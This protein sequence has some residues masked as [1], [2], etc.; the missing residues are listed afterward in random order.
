MSN[1]K[2]LRAKNLPYQNGYRDGYNDG[3]AAAERGCA[4]P[5]LRDQ[6]AMAVISNLRASDLMDTKEVVVAA[7]TYADLMLEVRELQI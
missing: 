3:K 5:T 7:Y 2:D 6:F 1:E 4:E